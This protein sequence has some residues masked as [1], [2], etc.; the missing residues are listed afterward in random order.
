[1]YN[2]FEKLK[3][4]ALNE[5]SHRYPDPFTLKAVYSIASG[6]KEELKFSSVEGILRVIATSM[7][8]YKDEELAKESS[9][10]VVGLTHRS[11][12]VLD[13]AIIFNSILL[14]AI[15]NDESL[16]S[17]EGKLELLESLK[18]DVSSNHAK[19]TLR[20]LQTALE[21]GFSKDKA[22]I[23]IG[24]GNFV[25]ESLGLS[26]Y[27]F[28]SEGTEYPFDTFV[29]AINSYW[30]FGADTDSIGFI[31]GSL[32]GAYHG[33]E[34]LPQNLIDDLENSEYY[35]KLADSLYDITNN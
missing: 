35:I 15:N 14:K 29:K 24:N 17:I 3:D 30:E 25:L 21:E 22:I 7:F 5:A 2:F 4:W 9:K 20:T 1:M 16:F 34:F 10:L 27:Y 26:T 6:S 28:L 33:Y 19:E 12:V 18:D 32:I 23:T 11:D 13:G 8:H 31:T